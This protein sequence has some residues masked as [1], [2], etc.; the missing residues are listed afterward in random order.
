[1]T[2]AV[3]EQTDAE[4]AEQLSLALPHPQYTQ[5]IRVR[6]RERKKILWTNE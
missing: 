3:G 6:V 4:T 5:D 2:D 1:M